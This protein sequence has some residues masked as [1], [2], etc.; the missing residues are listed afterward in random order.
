M[1]QQLA[2][3][4]G[5][6]LL[7][8]VE[9]PFEVDFSV[10]RDADEATLRSTLEAAL[11]N[12]S[13][14]ISRDLRR[15]QEVITPVDD[16]WRP[17]WHNSIAGAFDIESSFERPEE[18]PIAY[19]ETWYLNGQSATWSQLSR[20]VRL[21]VNQDAWESSII[22]T[23]RDHSDRRYPF[24]LY[25]VDPAPPSHHTPYL[26]P[27]LGHIILVQQ[28][29]FDCAAI[30]LTAVLPADGRDELVRVAAYTLNRLSISAAL[31]L[32]PLPSAFQLPNVRVRRGRLVFPE[33]GA[34]SIG[35][36]DSIVVERAQQV[37]ALPP[38]ELQEEEETSL[39]QIE[40]QIV[41]EPNLWTTFSAIPDF[42]AEHSCKGLSQDYK[43]DGSPY[44]PPSLTQHIVNAVAPQQVRPLHEVPPELSQLHDAFLRDAAVAVEEEGPVGFIDTW[45]LMCPREYVTEQSRLLQLDQYADE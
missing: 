2:L 41:S 15:P 35:N 12:F 33:Q 21:G 42:L 32:L 22:E 13:Q 25:F 1:H 26:R 28:P 24:F 20:R 34:P 17:D 45:Y 31:E 39:M 40:A 6:A 9:R 14:A 44:D 23:W 8:T 3:R 43:I 11:E 10:L 19:I 18:G 29:T 27:P 30:L 37:F 7:L 36:G 16:T 5:Y 38:N 4:H